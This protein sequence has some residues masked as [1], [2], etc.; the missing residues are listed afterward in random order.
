MITW[1]MT[2]RDPKWWQYNAVVNFVP[3]LTNNG[4]NCQRKNFKCKIEHSN[5]TDTS[6]H[7]TNSSSVEI[8]KNGFANKLSTSFG[9]LRK[10]WDICLWLAYYKE[11]IGSHHTGLLRGPNSNHKT[12]WLCNWMFGGN[13]KMVN[14]ACIKDNK[15]ACSAMQRHDI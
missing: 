9:A 3:L 14:T 7:K 1:S 4:F 6:F 15:A 13:C 12:C 11:P 8:S 2:S 5:W 10:R